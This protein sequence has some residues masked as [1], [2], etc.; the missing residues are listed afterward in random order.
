MVIIREGKN[1][2]K[3]LIELLKDTKPAP[4]WG[5]EDYTEYLLYKYRVC[6]YALFYLMKIDGDEKFIMPQSPEER[7]RII[8]ERFKI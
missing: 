6:D 5:S 8:K 2:S 7:D 1:I 3:G 4:V